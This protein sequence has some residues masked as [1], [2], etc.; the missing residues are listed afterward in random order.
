[1]K[2]LFLLR[3]AKS[4]WEDHGLSDFE[5]PLNERGLTAAP[6][7]GETMRSRELLPDVIIASP[8]KRAKQTA[9]LVR[10]AALIDSEL[11]FDG[12][13]Y[14]ASTSELL[15]VVL[16]LENDF[17]IAMMVGHNPGF[18]NL[19]RVLTGEF[20]IMPTA[21]LALIDLQI[22]QWRDIAPGSGNLQSVLR[23]KEL[24]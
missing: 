15:E 9:E 17:N 19:V 24:N 10:S 13:I 14:A 18:E 4:S 6:F 21:A 23:P 5:R 11:L 16:E 22:E 7:M 1:M 3:H 2:K 8:A 12:R 20:E